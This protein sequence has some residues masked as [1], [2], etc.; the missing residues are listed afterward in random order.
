MQSQHTFGKTDPKTGAPLPH[1]VPRS[2]RRP[3]WKLLALLLV[4]TA[5]LGALALYLT[6]DYMPARVRYIPRYV[7]SQILPPPD[8]PDHVPPPE[9]A[10]APEETLAQL[11]IQ[12]PAAPAPEASAPGAQE[13]VEQIGAPAAEAVVEPAPEP[14]TTDGAAAGAPEAVEPAPEALDAA[15]VP[16]AP[17]P[18]AVV[19]HPYLPAAAQTALPGIR[20]EYQGWNN[21]GPATLAMQLSYFGRTETQAVTAPFLKPDENDKNVSPHEMVAYAQSIGY[22]AREVVGMDLEMLRT[23]AT[24]G[25]PVVVESWYIPEP[26]DEMGHYLLLTGYDGQ[27][28]SFFDSYKGPNVAKNSEEFDRLWRV[29][30]RTAIVVWP[31]EKSDLAAAILAPVGEREQMYQNALDRAF[32]DVQADPNDRFG[33]FNLGSSLLALGEAEQ[34]AQAFDTARG[35]QLPW[36]MLWYQ[37]GPYEAYY[38]SGRYQEVVNLASATLASAGNLEESFY[39][40]GLAYEALGDVEAA[41]RDL[42]QAVRYN[43]NFAAAQQALAALP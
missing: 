31:P 1:R 3:P 43:P 9:V 18:A 25:F 41:R 32:A 6:W 34:A 20:H 27:T 17:P 30:N 4:V 38:R 39:W 33:W 13:P 5:L 12:R 16:V 2:R 22:E 26:N 37:F 8:H 35:L 21:C 23:L 28:L 40:R 10:A 42:G 36:R 7:Q 11:A 14:A 24:N 15:A 29:F 19:E